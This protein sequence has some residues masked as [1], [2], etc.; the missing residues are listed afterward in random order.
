MIPFKVNC[1]R[2][3]RLDDS[4]LN[5]DLYSILPTKQYIN[6]AVIYGWVEDEKLVISNNP[7]LIE[8]PISA[9]LTKQIKVTD[10]VYGVKD[11]ITQDIDLLR[12]FIS[13]DSESVWDDFMVED[14]E[15][16]FPSIEN[17]KSGLDLGYYLDI[18]DL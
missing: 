2:F 18:R 5:K 7:L 13:S 6:L 14:Y 9:V 11:V 16:D 3:V 10:I 17:L 15:P 1:S 4:L 12:V 8:G